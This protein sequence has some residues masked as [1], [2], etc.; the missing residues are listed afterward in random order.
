MLIA[1][2]TVDNADRKLRA[3]MFGYATILTGPTH[4]SAVTL[5]TDAVQQF[6]NKPYVF[7]KLEEDLYSL[8]R[9]QVYDRSEERQVSI[10]GVRPTEDV[11]VV[12]AFTAMS[13]FLKSRLG[14]GC[15]DE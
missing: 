1:R 12:G 13:E 14:A 3:G 11:V 2:A 9:I 10:T 8:R 4:E 5:P 15:V 7:V 6:E